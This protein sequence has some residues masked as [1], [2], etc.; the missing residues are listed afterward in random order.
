LWNPLTLFC[1]KA[2][3]G[4]LVRTHFIPPSPHANA[5]ALPFP[6]RCLSGG[7]QRALNP[8]ICA[9]AGNLKPH[10]SPSPPSFAAVG[11]RL[12]QVARSSKIGAGCRAGL[13]YNCGIGR[14]TH[15]TSTSHSSTRARPSDLDSF[16]DR[17][18]VPTQ[19]RPLGNSSLSSPSPSVRSTKVVNLRRTYHPSF[20]CSDPRNGLSPLPYG[21]S[22]RYH[23][24]S[25]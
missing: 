25:A 20:R 4:R 3:P 6:I 14:D 10:V 11:V 22:R 12:L 23:L 15:N 1:P 18:S 21:G 13:D 17:P 9:H 5:V 2:R 16:D 24:S 7:N 8:D 19:E